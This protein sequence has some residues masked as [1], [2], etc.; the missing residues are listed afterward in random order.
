[1]LDD[2]HN[3]DSLFGNEVG[4]D[5]DINLLK[6]YFFV[7]RDFQARFFS[8]KKHLAFVR[9][10]KGVG[11]SAL[12][13]YTMSKHQEDNPKDIFLYVKA[14]DLAL[15][16]PLD[17]ETTTYECINGWQR[18]IC[19]RINMEIGSQIGLALT[20]DKITLVEN[21]EIAGFKQKNIIGALVSR[22]EIKLADTQIN[23]K[24]LAACNPEELLKR[25]KTTS[26]E[27]IWM[28]IDDIDAN[29]INSE[30]KQLN[31]STF[32]TACRNLVNSIH[33]LYI[34]A[35]CR[36][37]VW[38]ILKDDDLDKCR[39]YMYDLNWSRQEI[40]NIMLN[41]ISSYFKR[42]YP[43]QYNS[44]DPNMNANEIF[45]LVF[46]DGLLKWGKGLVDPSIPIYTM[47]AGRP[48]WATVLCKLAA[49]HASKN[50]KEVID[51]KDINGSMF[52]YGTER[53]K[54]LYNEHNHQC[55]ALEKLIHTFAHG[56]TTYSL[57]DLLEFI[58]INIINKIENLQIDGVKT[59]VNNLGVANFL[60]RIGFISTKD[61]PNGSFLR[62][63]DRPDFLENDINLDLTQKWEI[64]PS[65]RR[66]LNIVN[67]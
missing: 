67:D 31:V 65:Y 16:I 41:R 21:S 44:L 28:F 27:N 4:E 35:A 43:D 59:N 10:R 47:S 53:L 15:L 33:G 62:F 55:N 63:E 52:N 26:K 22:L 1:M 40:R 5:E 23:K 14:S 64:H 20:D 48:R 12:L 56:R 38:N 61:S 54:D 58:N 24:S 17:K 11:K 45:K 34:R 36:S 51:V 19:S 50:D 32:F 7:K 2:L 57:K 37:D 8:T 30:L 60:F 66:V 39:Q 3:S 6:N 49:Q 29:F 13:K 18:R 25:Y 46:L 42:E 9:S